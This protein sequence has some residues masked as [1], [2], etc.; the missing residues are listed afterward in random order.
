MHSG[1]DAM[2]EFTLFPAEGQSAVST[3]DWAVAREFISAT[4]RIPG[5]DNWD[6]RILL[7]K[8][9]LELGSRYIR[10][11]LL[12]SPREALPNLLASRSVDIWMGNSVGEGS[13]RPARPDPT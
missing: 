3:V 8:E 1:P 5:R 9:P 11:I 4:L 10:G 2:L 12:L 13:V 6:C 7:K